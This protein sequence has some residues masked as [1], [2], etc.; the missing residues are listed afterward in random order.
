MR[1]NE[2]HLN[3]IGTLV[4]IALVALLSSTSSAQAA[5]TDKSS[6]AK[7]ATSLK[8]WL[9][10]KADAGGNYT[11][12]V[13]RSSF[14]GTRWVTTLVVRDNKIVERRFEVSSNRPQPIRPGA[15]PKKQG[16]KWIER[17]A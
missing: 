7:L 13:S 17:G 5:E 4:G 10:S 1:T 16:P 12:Q 14:I 3:V 6:N 9:K 8:V 11:Y 2:S 15:K